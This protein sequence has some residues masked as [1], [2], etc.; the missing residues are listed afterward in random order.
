MNEKISGTI[1]PE[2]ILRIVIPSATSCKKNA[3]Q[4]RKEHEEKIVNKMLK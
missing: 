1:K 4:R 3:P 2:M